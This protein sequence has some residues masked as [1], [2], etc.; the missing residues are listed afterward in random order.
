MNRWLLDRTRLVELS[1]NEGN[2][3]ITNR[4]IR[5]ACWPQGRGKGGQEQDVTV[6]I[7]TWTHRH[8][9]VGGGGTGSNDSGIE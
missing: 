4:P 7:P 1:P 8:Q 3:E 5:R 2:L 6:V 9:P